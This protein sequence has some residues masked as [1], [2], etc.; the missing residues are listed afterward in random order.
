MAGTPPVQAD[1]PVGAMPQGGILHV[2]IRACAT[3][4]YCAIWERGIQYGGSPIGEAG[5]MYQ[6]VAC[7][8]YSRALSTDRAEVQGRKQE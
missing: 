5:R 1:T 8:S 7:C 4:L 3:V 2:L 6:H